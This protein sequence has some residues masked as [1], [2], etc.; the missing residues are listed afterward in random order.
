VDNNAETD[1]V[2]VDSSDDKAGKCSDNTDCQINDEEDQVADS[3]T[4]YDVEVLKKTKKR[5]RHTDIM[6]KEHPQN[7]KNKGEKYTSDTT[8]KEVRAKFVQPDDCSKCRLRCSENINPE[9]RQNI[10]DAFYSLSSWEPQTTYITQSILQFE[11]RRRVA[12]D[13]ETRRQNQSR[14]YYLNV[15]DDAGSRSESVRKCL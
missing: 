3:D 15:V 8:K 12:G 1:R 9:H 11:P 14:S 13:A 4:L 7:E 5:V 6:E 10:F 2:Q